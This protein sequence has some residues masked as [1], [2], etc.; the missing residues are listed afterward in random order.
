MS[1]NYK[2]NRKQIG[3]QFTN[4]NKLKGRIKELHPSDS[5]EILSTLEEE[6]H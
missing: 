6:Q 2:L 5:E 3:K 4:K 1:K